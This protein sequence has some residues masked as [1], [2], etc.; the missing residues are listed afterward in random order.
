MTRVTWPRIV[1]AVAVL[2]SL[3]VAVMAGP[4]AASAAPSAGPVP[5]RATKRK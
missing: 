2:L 3:Q 4:G 1:R 5:Y